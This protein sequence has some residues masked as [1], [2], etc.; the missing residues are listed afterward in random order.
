MYMYIFKSIFVFFN[1]IQ[2]I[3][4]CFFLLFHLT[5]NSQLYL[6]ICFLLK[7]HFVSFLSTITVTKGVDSK[8]KNINFISNF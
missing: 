8:T 5:Y 2:L 3:L 6:L 1:L 7:L 4:L